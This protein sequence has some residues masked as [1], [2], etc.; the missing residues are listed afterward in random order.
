MSEVGHEELDHV[1]AHIAELKALIHG[2]RSWK[3]AEALPPWPIWS[4]T[5]G[6]RDCGPDSLGRQLAQLRAARTLGMTSMTK[7]SRSGMGRVMMKKSTPRTT[8]SASRSV[9]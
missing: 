1:R 7:R 5:S 6:D 2:D 3:S 9:T 4:G 8:S